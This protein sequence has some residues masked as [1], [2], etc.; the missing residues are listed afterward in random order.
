MKKWKV[1]L[2][3]VLVLALGLF[4]AGCG[5]EVTKIEWQ[6]LPAT[7]YTLGSDAKPEFKITVSFTKGDPETIDQTNEKVEIKNFDLSTAGTKTATVTYEKF[8]LNFTYT[9]IDPNTVLAGKGTAAEPYEISNAQQFTMILLG[10]QANK[11]TAHYKLTADIDF[12]DTDM[13]AYYD[14]L[15]TKDANGKYPVFAG[16]LD[17]GKYTA[18]GEYTG[19]NWKLMNYNAPSAAARGIAEQPGL[20]YVLGNCTFENLD[21]VNFRSV[22]SLACGAG[23]LGMG[24]YGKV[25]AVAFADKTQKVSYDFRNINVVNGYMTSAKNSAALVGYTYDNI[26]VNFEN[27][28]IDKNT[29]LIGDREIGGF[30][31]STQ[32]NTAKKT[33]PNDPYCA[34]AQNCS[35]AG[36]LIA[37][38]VGV[39]FGNNN[40][41]NESLRAS[42][43]TFTGTVYRTKNPTESK[44]IDDYNNCWYVVGYTSRANDFTKMTN[45]GTFHAPTTYTGNNFKK[46]IGVIAPEFVGTGAQKVK[47]AKVANAVRYVV[48]VRFFVNG[49]QYCLNEEVEAFETADYTTELAM[50]NKVY[51]VAYANANQI[52]ENL[53]NGIV[54]LS[55][56]PGVEQFEKDKEKYKIGNVV[57]TVV[58]FDENNLPIAVYSESSAGVAGGGV[59]TTPVMDGDLCVGY[60]R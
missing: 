14:A 18:Q 46:T 19:S 17:G 29:V 15:F 53:S 11:L 32:S 42:G 27:C 33:T 3:G 7:E 16:T 13:E 39:V 20:F 12:R 58:A 31:G 2:L 21:L 28:T 55:K 9:V 44:D 40:K 38:N 41:D 49:S 30:V 26:R 6:T 37:G 8:S 25:D 34:T 36:T 10:E 24:H 45:K 5:T 60:T 4:A 43:C 51:T 59:W 1:A 54:V 56:M 52:T 47:F 48:S 57:C 23:F 35:V 50:P 22:N